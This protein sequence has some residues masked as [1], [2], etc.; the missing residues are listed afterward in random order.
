MK[1]TERMTEPSKLWEIRFGILTGSEVNEH[2]EKSGQ[3]SF[4]NSIK[5]QK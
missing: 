4:G 5:Y 1:K 3:D 2:L